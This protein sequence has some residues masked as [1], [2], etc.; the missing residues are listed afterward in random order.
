[1]W[2]SVDKLYGRLEAVLQAEGL[3][4]IIIIIII[5]IIFIIFIFLYINLYLCQLDIQDKHSLFKLLLLWD[6]SSSWIK[7]SGTNVLLL[8]WIIN[9]IHQI[10]HWPS[11]LCGW[12]CSQQSTGWWL[13]WWTAKNSTSCWK[14]NCSVPKSL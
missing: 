7:L 6:G 3:S 1:M 9:T 4:I 5:I 12:L 13:I 8:D 11:R 10:N 2:L 14:N